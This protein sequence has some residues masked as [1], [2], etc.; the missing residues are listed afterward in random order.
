METDQKSLVSTSS[1]YKEFGCVASL[2]TS[3]NIISVLKAI[4]SRHGIPDTVVT[5]N[6]TYNMYT[7]WEFSQ[8]AESYN[9]Y[10][11]RNGE[12]EYVVVITNLRNYWWVNVFV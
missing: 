11:Q 8:F 1:K 7:S 9:Y 3:A 10:P 12:A 6:G 2:S 4:F 5:D